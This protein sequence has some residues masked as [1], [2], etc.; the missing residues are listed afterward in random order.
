MLLAPYAEASRAS[1]FPSWPLDFL[2]TPKNFIRSR[3]GARARSDAFARIQT[4][5]ANHESTE[6]FGTTEDETDGESD[7]ELDEN[8]WVAAAAARSLERRFFP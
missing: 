2:Q 8:T 6:R 5:V 4:F 3:H 1:G 7:D